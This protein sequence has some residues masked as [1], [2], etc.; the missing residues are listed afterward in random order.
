MALWQRSSS[1]T[2]RVVWF[3]CGLAVALSVIYIRQ[4]QRATPVK[5]AAQSAGLIASPR[6]AAAEAA[7][8]AEPAASP[9]PKVELA[10]SDLTLT[11]VNPLRDAGGGASGERAALQPA[12]DAL[13]RGDALTARR[14]FADALNSG[15]PP[16]ARESVRAELSRLADAAVFSPLVLPG[17]GLAEHYVVN[18]GDT[19]ASIAKRYKITPELIARMNEL[20]NKDR[21]LVGTPLKVV[22]GPFCGRVSK[23]DFRLDVLLDGVMVRS[24]PVG[25]GTNGSTPTGKWVVRDKLANPGWTDPRTNEY[26]HPDAPDNPIGDYWIGLEGIEGEAV[27]KRG[28][29][30]HGTIDPA[31]IGRQMSL[32]CVRLAP[33][34]IEAVF[35]LLVIGDSTLEI[36]D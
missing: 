30:V 10:R 34:D 20:T 14:I 9:A 21:L 33:E 19:L 17:D 22:H 7:E 15:L 24:F 13:S 12:R 36:V 31:S 27:G 25:L 28:F 32:G 5:D 3:L 26:Y 2:V 35:R 6:A 23:G 8:S 1:S 11:A 16:A 4:H 29:G 18:K